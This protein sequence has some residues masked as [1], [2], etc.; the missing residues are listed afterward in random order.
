MSA[1]NGPRSFGWRRKV[2]SIS[3]CIGTTR[4]TRLRYMWLKMEY[5]NCEIVGAMGLW[6]NSAFLRLTVKSMRP[7]TT[8]CTSCRA[9][10][11]SWWKA[12]SRLL[13]WETISERWVLTSSRLSQNKFWCTSKRCIRSC[14][15]R[16]MASRMRTGEIE[17]IELIHFWRILTIDVYSISYL[18]SIRQ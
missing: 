12:G 18:C 4:I 16:C 3:L 2:P 15:A 1:R 14:A 17:G 7:T 10:I 11:P 8:S 13:I 9:T 5:S 6:L